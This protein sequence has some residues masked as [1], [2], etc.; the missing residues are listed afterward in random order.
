[1]RLRYIKNV[2]TLK[3]DSQKCIGCGR[4]VEVCPH[5]VFAIRERK[6]QLNDQDLCIECGACQQNCP[7]SA[8]TVRAGVGCA[9][10]IIKGKL[11]GTEPDCGCS[12]NSCCC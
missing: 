2:V 9:S 1:M 12:D 7:V 5:G 6:A 10:A 3:L 8:I 11:K 4:C